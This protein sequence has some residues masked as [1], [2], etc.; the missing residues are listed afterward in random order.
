MES[1]ACGRQATKIAMDSE[2]GP[3]LLCDECAKK[4]LA[5]R[6]INGAT[7]WQVNSIEQVCS[8][9]KD[10]PDHRLKHAA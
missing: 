3:E 5:R 6:N 1:C 10:H 8:C 7:V 2:V 4:W 9:L